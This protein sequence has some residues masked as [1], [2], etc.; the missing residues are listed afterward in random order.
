MILE[1]KRDT[2]TRGI[3]HAAAGR[4]KFSLAR[5]ESGPELMPFVEHYWAVRYDLPPG[6]THTQTILSFPNVHL[7][8]EHDDEGRRAL[9]YG[10]PERPFV[11]RLRGT[12]K[13]LGVKFRAGGFYPFWQKDVA[14]LTGTTVPAAALF[15]S[16]A[17][18]WLRRVL[19]AA[20]PAGMARQA[21]AALLSILPGLSPRA[22]LADRIVR[23]A[24]RDRDIVS[25]EQ[26]AA[27]TGLSVR[28]LQRLFR[29]Y[30]GV[31]PKWVIKRFRLQ[32]AAERIE[33]DEAASLAELAAQLGYFDQ[34]HFIKDFKAVLGVS[35]TAY[36]KGLHD[37]T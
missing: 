24:M 6:T 28:R 20:E 19:D 7:A 1:E 8:F 33:R 35:P 30:V 27:R 18:R 12:G 36:R 29:K 10:I 22:E 15:G 21:E 4:D 11:R 32:E 25:V 37:R 14:S 17:D 34:A 23:E 2:S 31:S 26:L 13:V 16:A 5:F 9:I 3:V